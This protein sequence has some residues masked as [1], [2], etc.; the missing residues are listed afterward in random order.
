MH[1]NAPLR[2]SQKPLQRTRLKPK[3]R[4]R[5]KHEREIAPDVKQ[6]K[7]DHGVCWL[8]RSRYKRPDLHHCAGKEHPECD[9]RANWIALCRECHGRIHDNKW[10]AK[11]RDN[12][13]VGV[14]L[15]LALK[16]LYDLDLVRRVWGKGPE[17]I[18]EDDV[19]WA[20]PLVREIQRSGG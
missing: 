2:R 8:C 19:T 3:S 6:F 14:L 4:K 16:Q 13:T 5:A 18:T 10:T 7:L 20:I 11:D 1:R 17:C 9:N 15:C 12:K